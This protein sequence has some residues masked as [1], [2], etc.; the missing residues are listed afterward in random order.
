MSLDK[1]MPSTIHP[2]VSTTR[3]VP[4][5][6]RSLSS[7]PCLVPRL[8]YAV[9]FSAKVG[10]GHNNTHEMGHIFLI[11]SAPCG[12]LKGGQR[13]MGAKIL[14]QKTSLSH[15]I[16]GSNGWET[17]QLMVIIIWILSKNRADV[18]IVKADCGGRS[19]LPTG[20]LSASRCLHSSSLDTSQREGVLLSFPCLSK[21]RAIGVGGI[22]FGKYVLWAPSS[23]SATQ[24]SSIVPSH[25]GR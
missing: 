24:T 10:Y 20:V 14:A 12:S 21:V 1:V 3:R 22:A 15:A 16:R 7:P 8:A 19:P 2:P 23:T 17:D 18:H 4:Y 11:L 9:S 13:Y 25:P 5:R 6:T